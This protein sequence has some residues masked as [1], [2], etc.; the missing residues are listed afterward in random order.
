M[1]TW[2]ELSMPHTRDKHTGHVYTSVIIIRILTNAYANRPRSLLTT[3][4]MR[5]HASLFARID[6]YLAIE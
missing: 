1:W 6:A 4:F 2:L 3:L 5:Y